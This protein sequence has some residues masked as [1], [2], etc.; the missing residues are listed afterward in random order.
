MTTDYTQCCPTQKKK[1]TETPTGEPKKKKRKIPSEDPDYDPLKDREQSASPQ[2]STSGYSSGPPKPSTTPKPPNIVSVLPAHVQASLN[3]NTNNTS[4]KTV[5]TQFKPRIQVVS[6][7][8]SN[9]GL[10]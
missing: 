9:S 5:T 6:S 7:T 8:A 10:S 2:P 4:N 3:V 1:A